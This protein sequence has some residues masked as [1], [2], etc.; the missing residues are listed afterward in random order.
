METLGYNLLQWLCGKLPWEKE[1][2]LQM[3]TVNPE[4]IQAQKEKIF[5]D[6]SLSIQKCF[7][8]KRKAPGG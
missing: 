2:E 1:N 8:G 3:S 4:E 7:S 6:I 5:S